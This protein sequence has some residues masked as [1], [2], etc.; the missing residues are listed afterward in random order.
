MVSRWHK[1]PYAA[2]IVMHGWQQLEDRLLKEV[3]TPIAIVPWDDS[4]HLISMRPAG[5]VYFIHYHPIRWLW[6]ESC[7]VCSTELGREAE[8]SVTPRKFVSYVVDI[9]LIPEAAL[10]IAWWVGVNVMPAGRELEVVIFQLYIN[11]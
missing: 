11:M 3:N 9:K 8:Y 7:F 4:D 1:Q 6:S 5:E 2:E 10:R